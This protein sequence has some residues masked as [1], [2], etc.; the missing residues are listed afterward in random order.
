MWPAVVLFF[1]FAW[2][3]LVWERSDVPSDLALAVL[4]YCA[5]TWTGMLL[6]GGKTWLD[7]GETF[8]LIFGVFARFA[9][10]EFRVVNAKPEWNLRPPAVGL[11]SDEPVHPSL[12][13]LV[14]LMLATVTFDGLAETP[15]W[16]SIA[17]NFAQWLPAAIASSRKKLRTLI[18]LS[19]WPVSGRCSCRFTW[20]ARGRLAYGGRGFCRPPAKRDDRDRRVLDRADAGADCDRLSPGPLSCRFYDGRSY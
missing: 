14:V 1:A 6:F 20:R 2:T 18:A 16:A 9:P 3:E 8:A 19:A 5:I 15:L 10:T 12:M 11:L 7:H 17:D 4:V 13:A